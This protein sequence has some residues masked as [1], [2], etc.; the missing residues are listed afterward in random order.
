M[1]QLCSH[2][3]EVQTSL[4]APYISTSLLLLCMLIGTLC[5]E[6]KG[7]PRGTDMAPRLRCEYLGILFM[8]QAYV[9]LIGA[10]LNFLLR[11]C[12]VVLCAFP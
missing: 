7:T 12:V 6:R 1:G 11:S 3:G 8:K 10:T 5:G 9:S 2:P 4:M